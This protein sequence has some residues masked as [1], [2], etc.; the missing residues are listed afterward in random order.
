MKGGEMKKHEENVFSGRSRIIAVISLDTQDFK[1]W[2]LESNLKPD[3]FEYPKKF[4]VGNELYIGISNVYELCSIHLD[5]VIETKNAKMNKDYEQIKY[6]AK[7]SCIVPEIKI[8]I[9]TP[10][11]WSDRLINNQVGVI[12][13]IQKEAWNAAL[14]EVEALMRKPCWDLTLYEDIK[15]LKK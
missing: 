12:K 8:N 5:S 10:E 1:N 4:K 11:E 15:K 13:E 2:K 6:A 7:A 14:E 3:G 9:K